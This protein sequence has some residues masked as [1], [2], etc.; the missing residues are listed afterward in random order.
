MTL[1]EV[2]ATLL[3]V[4]LVTGLIWT[5]ISISSRSSVLETNKLR[6]QQEGNYISTE[7]L[8]IHRTCKEYEFVITPNNVSVENCQ[9]EK[10][11][12]RKRF[13]ISEGFIYSM[14]DQMISPEGVRYDIEADFEDLEIEKFKITSPENTKLSITFPLIAS[15][16]KRST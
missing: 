10:S 14:G 5:T 6:L 2:L 15:R 16:Y 3:L 7:I 1:V 8:R 11:Q 12:D 4:T 9:I 13:S